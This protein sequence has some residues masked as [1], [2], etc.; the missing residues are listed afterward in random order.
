[1]LLS[2]ATI[3]RPCTDMLHHH[4][5]KCMVSA[6]HQNWCH[7]FS[8]SEC[9]G[10]LFPC[11]RF[12]AL[13]VEPTHEL[14]FA[15]RWGIPKPMP[16]RREFCAFRSPCT[17]PEA[18]RAIEQIQVARVPFTPIPV[19]VNQCWWIGNW[20]WHVKL[21]GH[22]VNVAETKHY[23]TGSNKICDSQAK[24]R[25]GRRREMAWKRSRRRKGEE[26][27]GGGGR[28]RR[29]RRRRRRGRRRRRRR[30]SGG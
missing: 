26:E 10:M 21:D 24:L 16:I 8:H 11:H 4:R 7:V 23:W 9:A 12:T 6:H 18:P 1:M 14:L 30:T 19:L 15:S 29:R 22:C 20:W 17:L 5:S 28:R 25:T 13:V 27:E 2:I 3:V